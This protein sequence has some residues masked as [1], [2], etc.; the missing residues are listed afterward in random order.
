MGR[1]GEKAAAGGGPPGT[2][3]PRARLC[4]RGPFS[5]GHIKGRAAEKCSRGR[6]SQQK[7]PA[8]LRPEGLVGS[9]AAAARGGPAGS[10][11]KAAPRSHTHA[12]LAAEVPPPAPG[13][14][15]G[16]APVPPGRG[17]R[18]AGAGR[19]GRR[20]PACSRL[21][22]LPPSLLPNGCGR[23][24]TCGHPG[25]AQ[26]APGSPLRS[27]GSGEGGYLQVHTQSVKF[28]LGQRLN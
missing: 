28:L 2:S 17:G 19:V 22:Q 4:R 14:S 25:T 20:F 1:G 7:N 13:G 10:G 5:A 3:R 23:T 24:H 8:Q 12:R 9:G 26:G 11:T 6:T 15:A 21:P 18:Q 16:P 27:P